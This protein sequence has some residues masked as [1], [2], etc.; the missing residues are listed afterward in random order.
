M[1]QGEVSDPTEEGAIGG[2]SKTFTEKDH[3]YH[4]EMSLSLGP[5]L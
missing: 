3:I 4:R 2:R 1:N 5:V